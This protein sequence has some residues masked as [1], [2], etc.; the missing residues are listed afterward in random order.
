M[1]PGDTLPSHSVP[2]LDGCR[3]G[4][5]R[6]GG[7]IKLEGGPDKVVGDVRDGLGQ[8]KDIA[9]DAGQPPMVLILKVRPI[10]PLHHL[11]CRQEEAS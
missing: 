3:G 6:R 5:S 11:K 1:C 2:H 9:V 10:A 4:S 8:K 7:A